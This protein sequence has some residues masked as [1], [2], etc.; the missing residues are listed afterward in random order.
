M[1]DDRAQFTL[2]RVAQT[3]GISSDVFDEQ[4]SYSLDL[5]GAPVGVQAVELL[6]LFSIISD[7]EVRQSCL[8]YVREAAQ[9]AKRA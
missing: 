8:A 2:Q 1:D 6:N 9:R 3:L 5:S 7:P 4:T